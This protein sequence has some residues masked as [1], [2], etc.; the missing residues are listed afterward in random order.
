MSHDSPR[1]LVQ[2]LR[3]GEWIEGART[4]PLPDLIRL[5]YA[6]HCESA[7]LQEKTVRG[8]DS[9]ANAYG[10]D[11]A[12][13]VQL[14]DYL[15]QV[16]NG[17]HAQWFGNGCATDGWDG[18]SVSNVDLKKRLL[19]RSRAAS[20]P[21]CTPVLAEAMQLCRRAHPTMDDEEFSELDQ[22]F[23]LL[24]DQLR[25]DM[26]EA[27]IRTWPLD[28]ERIADDGERY[29]RGEA[30]VAALFPP[31][32]GGGMRL[33]PAMLQRLNQVTRAFNAL[34]KIPTLEEVAAQAALTGD[35]A[36]LYR[37]VKTMALRELADEA[38]REEEGGN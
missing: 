26:E 35:V 24:S 17:G 38:G 5:V 4:L 8:L 22:A 36:P 19:A 15:R 12:L 14:L 2:L 31:R 33:D 32:G 18:L 3:S 23:Y 27:C 29:E 6:R 28:V 20:P 1:D 13:S 16:N 10:E 21:F 30:F 7:E 25:S 37:T 11:A 9:F 34:V